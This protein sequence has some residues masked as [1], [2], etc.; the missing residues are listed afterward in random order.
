M[1]VDSK[2][3]AGME[4]SVGSPPVGASTELVWPLEVLGDFKVPWQADS[5][6]QL[7]LLDGYEFSEEGKCGKRSMV[8]K[9]NE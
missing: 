2:S 9:T 6:E 1:L 8:R 5:A 3:T 4:C 7:D